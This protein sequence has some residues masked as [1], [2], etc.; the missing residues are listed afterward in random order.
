[1]APPTM[2]QALVQPSPRAELELRT[3]PVPKPSAGD[4][5]VKVAA[6]TVHSL[7]FKILRYGIIAQ[8]WPFTGGNEFAGTV[9]AVGL[10]VEKIRIDDRVIATSV[11]FIEGNEVSGWQ[12]YAL[13]HADLCTKIPD[14]LS[15]P[16]AAT[17][18]TSFVTASIALALDL[19]LKYPDP[20][21]APP[22]KT[23]ASVWATALASLKGG[24]EFEFDLE[25]GV[26]EGGSWYP[27]E[28]AMSKYAKCHGINGPVAHS[29]LPTI[30]SS[31]QNLPERERKR[32]LEVERNTVNDRTFR[33]SANDNGMAPIPSSYVPVQ[34]ASYRPQPVARSLPA[35]RYSAA[36]RSLEPIDLGDPWDNV[37]PMSWGTG[38]L[39][40]E[41]MDRRFGSGWNDPERAPRLAEV[42]VGVTSTASS[43]T[44]GS[45]NMG[46]SGSD[47]SYTSIEEIVLTTPKAK[48]SGRRGSEP[49]TLL[50]RSSGSAGSGPTRRANPNPNPRSRGST[51]PFRVPAT[52]PLR[53]QGSPPYT[54]RVR[55]LSPVFAAAA[56]AAAALEPLTTEVRP[57][58]AG[59]GASTRSVVPTGG[60]GSGATTRHTPR[61]ALEELIY[62]G[63]A[64]APAQPVVYAMDE[65]ILVWGGATNVG[66]NALQLLKR[67]GYTN[68][69]VVASAEKCVELSKI[70]PSGTK[71]V[72]PSPPLALELMD[73]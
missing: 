42:G 68:V 57:V 30:P 11:G 37:H 21:A 4:V 47:E 18:P 56:A 53:R 2:Q 65:P 7:D 6:S 51:S 54:I 60:G 29:H 62:K 22:R 69:F 73:W 31:T 52:I 44:S 55:D 41:A 8:E 38:D 3:V 13:V 17:V 24:P 71:Y 49:C 59:T 34:S 39:S 14:S 23:A 33:L 25:D 43:T 58:S 70:A 32:I 15:F 19:G 48:P 46:R 64:A 67:A 1:M 61:T 16:Q 12:E 50:R 45:S 66:R 5:L 72:L 27:S 35:P 26:V 20:P 28:A 40:R 10:G 36:T 63:Q 9:V